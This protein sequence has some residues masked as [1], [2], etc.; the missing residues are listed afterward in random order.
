[1]KIYKKAKIRYNE[2]NLAYVCMETNS[3]VVANTLNRILRYK[4]S[5]LYRALTVKNAVQILSDQLKELKEYV[6]KIK[7]SLPPKYISKSNFRD[8]KM[9]GKEIDRM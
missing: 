7:S 4:G 1:M 2:I 3:G 6:G 5:T 9:K 8:K